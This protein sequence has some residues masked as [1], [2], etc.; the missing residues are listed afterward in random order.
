M[1]KDLRYYMQLFSQRSNQDVAV[2]AVNPM[3]VLIG[4]TP[5]ATLHR[6][7]GGQSGGGMPLGIS[8]CPPN[9]VA[10]R[11]HAAISSILDQDFQRPSFTSHLR[12][13]KCANCQTRQARL[14]SVVRLDCDWPKPN[15]ACVRASLG[16]RLV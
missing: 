6:D 8:Q 2:D 10:H 16:I 1:N 12:K 9:L 7:R 14:W 15:S 11:R 3:Y 4:C 5:N 13:E